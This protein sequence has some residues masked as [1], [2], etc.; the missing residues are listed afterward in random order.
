VV[1]LR[2][3]DAQS[4]ARDAA[5]RGVELGPVETRSHE[6]RIRLT[7]PDGNRLVV[8]SPPAS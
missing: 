7:D 1:S 8:Y 6:R 3:A 2:V 4:W 5:A